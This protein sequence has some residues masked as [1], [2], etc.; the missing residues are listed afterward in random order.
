MRRVLVSLALLV[1]AASAQAGVVNGT[2][3]DGLNGWIASGGVGIK[4]P[5]DFG[6][7]A[8]PSGGPFAAVISSWGGDWGGPLGS[9]TQIV[10]FTG[11]G[12]LTGEIY[13]AAH[14]GDA[15]R[16][17]ATQVLWN[18]T[19]VA[20]VAR[21]ADPNRWADA[22]PWVSFSVPV[23]GIGA[24]ELKVNFIV[25]FA[26]WSW[27]AADNLQVVPEPGSLLALGTGLVSLAGLALR[28]RR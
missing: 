6:M 21:D 10:N 14:S 7:P 3:D 2:F 24:N 4:N 27:T 22:F 17:V 28:R 9:I 12:L 1:L 26:E 16:N 15:W 25:H 23:T 13:A 11:D 18:G 5:G 8:S 19:V 20:S